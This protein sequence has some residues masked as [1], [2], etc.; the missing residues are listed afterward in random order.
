MS[1]SLIT[2]RL[3]SILILVIIFL[4]ITCIVTGA[5]FSMPNAED[6]G[7]AAG[8]QKNGLWRSLMLMLL[9]ND[10]RYSTNFFHGISPLVWWE[11]NSYFLLPIISFSIF[12]ICI[13]IFLK[14]CFPKTL[15]LQLLT[16]GT[17]IAAVFFSILESIGETLY[18][19]GGTLVYVFP[20]SFSLLWIGVLLCFLRDQKAIYFFLSSVFLFLALGFNEMFLAF[21]GI[22]LVIALVYFSI[23][24]IKLL[25]LY[26][27][28]MAVGLSGMVLMLTLPGS[29]HKTEANN[30]ITEQI[31]NIDFWK[32]FLPQYLQ[33]ITG[34]YLSIAVWSSLL[35]VTLVLNLNIV[36]DSITKYL[37]FLKVAALLLFIATFFMALIFYLPMY[38]GVAFPQRAYTPIYFAWYLSTSI[39][40]IAITYKPLKRNQNKYR[41]E[42]VVLFSCVILL[43][44]VTESQSNYRKM[45]NDYKNGRF[46]IFKHEM[47]KRFTILTNATKKDLPW[48]KAIIPFLTNYPALIYTSTEPEANRKAVN[49]NYAYEEYFG[50]DD[51]CMEGDTLKR[52]KRIDNIK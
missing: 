22:S 20:C 45:Y 3:T 19:W 44:G 8:F 7:L 41:L 23:Y 49:W 25:K 11:I 12:V 24:S 17:G 16:V 47:G 37:N 28:L 52:F 46:N 21:T 43:L 14:G 51:V 15:F 2:T 38:D 32:A 36:T 31:G 4:S 18:C 29:W 13:S 42:L 35:L 39:F 6:L 30:S 5:V 26:L 48:N 33:S 1:Y 40:L 9:F 34:F 10:G 27:P 50:I